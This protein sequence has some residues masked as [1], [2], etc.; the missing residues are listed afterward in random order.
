MFRKKTAESQRKDYR[1]KEAIQFRSRLANIIGE[2]FRIVSEA[3]GKP[4]N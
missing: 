4:K 1:M 3:G 2:T